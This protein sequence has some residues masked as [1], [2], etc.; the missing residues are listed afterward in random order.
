[1]HEI[2]NFELG[3]VHHIISFAPSENCYYRS[4]AFAFRDGMRFHS[5]ANEKIEV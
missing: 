2:S 3:L 1:M 5:S 4:Y